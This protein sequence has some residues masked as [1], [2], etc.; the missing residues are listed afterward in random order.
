MI[1][2]NYLDQVDEYLIPSQILKNTYRPGKYSMRDSLS[3]GKHLQSNTCLG[4]RHG[5]YETSN[6]PADITKPRQTTPLSPVSNF[7]QNWIAF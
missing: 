3:H 7:Y 5:S 6:S 2:N 1:K 4:I